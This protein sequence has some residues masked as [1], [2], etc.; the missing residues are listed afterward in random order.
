MNDNKGRKKI[1]HTLLNISDS[2][3]S[4]NANYENEDIFKTQS[5]MLDTQEGQSKYISLGKGVN[6]LK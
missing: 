5:K 4:E 2:F 6:N 3:G 1:K